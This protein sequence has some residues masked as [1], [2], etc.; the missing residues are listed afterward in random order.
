M[1]GPPEFLLL[2]LFPP[3]APGGKICQPKEV[4]S[5]PLPRGKISPGDYKSP[6]WSPFQPTPLVKKS[7]EIPLAQ[8]L[9]LSYPLAFWP[10]KP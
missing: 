3:T 2:P 4:F 6:K 7:R 9:A 5:P 1:R 10:Q 8:N